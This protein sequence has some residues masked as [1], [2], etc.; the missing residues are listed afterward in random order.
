M[1]IEN[2]NDPALLTDAFHEKD[3]AQA[4]L[5]ETFGGTRTPLLKGGLG[6]ARA[7]LR[8]RLGRPAGHPG[9]LD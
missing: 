5:R 1:F 7:Q 6:I 3:K 9:T 8:Q 2:F 4:V